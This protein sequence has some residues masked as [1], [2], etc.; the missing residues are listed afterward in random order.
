MR[1][2]VYGIIKLKLFIILLIKL[3]SK[4]V[5]INVKTN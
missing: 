2:G 1:D 5:L 4:L 3:F